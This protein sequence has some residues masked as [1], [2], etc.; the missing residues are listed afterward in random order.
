MTL[1]LLYQFIHLITLIPAQRRDCEPKISLSTHRAI[2]C[3]RNVQD[4]P[5]LPYNF[6][7]MSI[8]QLFL[9]LA[10]TSTSSY[11]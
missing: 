1:Y 4:P 8:N 7:L 5:L 10:V 9:K 2:A 3:A 11:S 6:K